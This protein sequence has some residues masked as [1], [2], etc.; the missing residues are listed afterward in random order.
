MTEMVHADLHLE[1]FGGAQP[2]AGARKD[3]VR[4]VEGK[5]TVESGGQ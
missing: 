1:S 3:R 4:L 5:V 2:G